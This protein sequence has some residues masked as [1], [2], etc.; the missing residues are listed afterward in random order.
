[1]KI[2]D[3]LDFEI[4]LRLLLDNHIHENVVKCKG[5][6]FLKQKVNLGSMKLF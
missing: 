4:K 5:K 2:L 6:I 3:K 1:M